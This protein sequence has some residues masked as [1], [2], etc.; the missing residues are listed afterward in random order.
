ML[1]GHIIARQHAF[2]NGNSYAAREY[3][4]HRLAPTFLTLPAKTS[5]ESS[6]WIIFS[7]YS[8]RF[9]AMSLMPRLL[10]ARKI[11]MID[12]ER[13]PDLLVSD[14]RWVSLSPS[15]SALPL[16]RWMS[17]TTALGG[18]KSSLFRTTLSESADLCDLSRMFESS[19]S[20]STM[21]SMFWTETNPDMERSRIMD[22]SLRT[23]A[24][25]AG[26]ARP[27]ERI[28]SRKES[29]CVSNSRHVRRADM[30]VGSFAGMWFVTR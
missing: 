7:L 27:P 10:R 24:S 11:D 3:V 21:T 22:I 15:V 8:G 5:R 20:A 23:D 26:N 25:V 12:S 6:R 14:T 30:R 4:L 16:V 18:T 29:T 13:R 9:A 17:D 1:F 28:S 2:D 19:S